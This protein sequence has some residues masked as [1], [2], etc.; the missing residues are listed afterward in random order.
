VQ[1]SIGGKQTIALI[2]SGSNASF[3]DFSFATTLNCTLT[4][5]ATSNITVAGGGKLI[6][7][8]IIQNCHFSIAKHQF[9]EDFRV[10]Q[11]PDSS[12]ILG[13]DWLKKHSLVAFDFHKKIFTMH[14]FG[15]Y[16][17]TFPTCTAQ[18]QVIEISAEKMDKLLS[19]NCSGFIIPLN[20]LSAHSD[21]NTEQLP[22]ISQLL[23]TFS[24]VFAEP[25]ELP[26]HRSCDHSIH[27]KDG[28]IPLAL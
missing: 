13:C 19:K 8:S 14:K 18:Q 11:L 6:S 7:N 2:D 26:P 12:V 10:L 15:C 23:M 24:D 4:H 20:T 25:M 16:P 9:V 3:V 21:S 22:E 28:A 27:L 1:I 5:S 17:V